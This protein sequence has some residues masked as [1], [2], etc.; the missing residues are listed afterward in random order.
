LFEFSVLLL[1]RRENESLE[2][3]RKVFSFSLLIKRREKKKLGLIWAST[4]FENSTSK[5]EGE[6]KKETYSIHKSE[7]R[8]QLNGRAT[9]QSCKQESRELLGNL[10]ALV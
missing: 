1:L 7:R 3:Y 9:K 5:S 10:L 8:M 4:W 6:R 2:K